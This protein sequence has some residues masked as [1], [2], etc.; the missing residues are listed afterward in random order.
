MPDDESWRRV[1]RADR[2]RQFMPF[3]ALRGYYEMVE[4]ASNPPEPKREL[5]ADE[6]ELLDAAFKRLERGSL[7]RVTYHDGKRYVTSEGI[8]TG[9]DTAR[10][11]IRVVKTVIPLDDISGLEVL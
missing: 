1:A 8:V 3:A 10:R 5:S 7:V 4:E 9:V 6:L 2:A 11:E